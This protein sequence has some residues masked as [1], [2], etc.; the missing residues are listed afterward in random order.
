MMV[1]QSLFV[2]LSTYLFI[3]LSIYPSTIYYISTAISPPS[4]SPSSCPHLP[5]P[6]DT[7]LLQFPFRKEQASQVYEPNMA[8]QVQ[9][10]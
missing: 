5:S 1:Y 6:P 8:Y 2:C 10:D 9:Y 4:S 7:L 3:Y